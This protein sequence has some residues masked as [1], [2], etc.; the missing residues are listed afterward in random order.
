MQLVADIDA[1]SS[2][3]RES[4]ASARA[5][6]SNA[7]LDKP[8]GTLR[9]RI[10]IRPRE[11]AGKRHMRRQAEAAARPPPP[12]FICATA[13]SVRAADCR[14]REA[15]RSRRRASSYAGCTATSCPCKC[16]DNS[17][18]HTPASLTVCRN[19]S[20]YASL[21]GGLF[22]VDQAR[23]G[24]HL[25]AFEAQALRPCGQMR[26]VIERQFVAEKLREEDRRSL[27]GFHVACSMN[28]RAF[29]ENALRNARESGELRTASSG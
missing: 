2:K 23:I 13:H 4:G 27:D 18:M 3:H 5:S 15:R 9:P 20:Q 29:A 11:R 19:S 1:A 8:R 21:V 25:D 7:V 6:S 14:A 28:R 24:G 22:E 10:H 17:V 12:C 16:V 26:E